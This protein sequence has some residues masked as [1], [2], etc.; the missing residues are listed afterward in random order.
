M[1][2]ISKAAT[3]L[4]ALVFIGMTSGSAFAD[5]IVLVKPD[6]QKLVPPIAALSLQPF[7]NRSAHESGGVDYNGSQDVIFGAVAG[8]QH[9]VAFSDLGLGRA[10]DLL[11]LLNINE[12]SGN[13]PPI[14]IE[15]FILAA[16]DQNGKRAF[17]ASFIQAPMSL[18]PFASSDYAFGLDSEAAARLEAAVAANP[19]LRLGLAA[20]LFNVSGGPERFMYSGMTAPVPEPATMVL[21]ATSLVGLAGAARRRRKAATAFRAA[22]Q[23]DV[24]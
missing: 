20:S 2:I 1:K 24:S 15:G 14:T 3:T 21:F 22:N 13:K 19:T 5:G 6:I 18:D 7:E 12:S 4:S 8:P 11:I 10:S 16:Y 23:A 9:T 17:M